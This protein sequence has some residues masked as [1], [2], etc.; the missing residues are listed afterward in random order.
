MSSKATP[1]YAQAVAPPAKGK[2]G[3]QARSPVSASSVAV[4][5][6]E[7]FTKSPPPLPQ[8]VRR[9]FASRTTFEPH[10]EALKIA[11]YFS[12]IAVSVLRQAN[13]SLPLSF[14]CT[15]NDKG[16][17][18]LLG[19]NLYTLGSAYT[20]YFTLLT[21][22]LNK[23][24]PV[25]NSSWVLFKPAPNEMQLL[26]HSI[27]LAFLPSDDAQLFPSLHGSIHN[28]RGVSIVS[29]RYLNL[30]QESRGQ[31]STTS[32]VVPV[33]PPDAYAIPPSINLFSRNRRVEQIFSSSK[34]SQWKK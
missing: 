9:S 4:A 14:T 8:A 7:V 2:K 30:D 1:T 26:I 10:P 24:F 13:C 15:V 27:P 34:S 19:T 6:G 32:V 11:A 5:S 17:V 3:G 21:S 18:S 29:A 33:A 22:R 16:S 31:K 28:P 25:G 20:P 12:D 23:V